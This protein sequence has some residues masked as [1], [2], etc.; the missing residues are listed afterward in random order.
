MPSYRVPCPWCP[1]HPKSEQYFSHLNSKH[2]SLLW[3][4]KSLDCLKT[5]IKNKSIA[6][7]T[8]TLPENHT[9]YACLGCMTATTNFATAAKH[10]RTCSEA[11]LKSLA[12]WR[13][14]DEPKEIPEKP[15]PAVNQ[16]VLDKLFEKVNLKVN[17]MRKSYLN[18]IKELEFENRELRGNV[19]QEEEEQEEDDK[20]DFREEYARFLRTLGLIK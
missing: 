14:Q 16:E 13:L 17:T 10:E 19:L 2:Y 4:G 11:T 5:R 15:Q 6:P 18:R 9:L 8:I 7:I 12:E 3:S 1:A 20:Y